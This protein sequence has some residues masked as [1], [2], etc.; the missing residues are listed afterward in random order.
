MEGGKGE[1]K[2]GIR[3]VHP[4]RNTKHIIS[5]WETLQKVLVGCDHKNAAWKMAKMGGYSKNSTRFGRFCS[6]GIEDVTL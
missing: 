3:K 1:Y 2:I 6:C 5:S 4:K